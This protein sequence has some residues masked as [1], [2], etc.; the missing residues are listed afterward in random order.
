VVLT[1][2]PVQVVGAAAKA[3]IFAVPG[4]YVVP[5]TFGGEA[6]SVDVILRG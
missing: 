3:N 5:V 4:G 1:Q 6:K 2:D